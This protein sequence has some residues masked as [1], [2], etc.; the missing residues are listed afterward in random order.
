MVFAS[1]VGAGWNPGI[2]CKVFSAARFAVAAMTCASVS[3]T[4]EVLFLSTSREGS[5]GSGGCR[6]YSLLGFS[7]GEGGGDGTTDGS[8]LSNIMVFPLL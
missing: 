5:R 6:L 2:N 3:A 1:V 7:Y 8:I 4:A